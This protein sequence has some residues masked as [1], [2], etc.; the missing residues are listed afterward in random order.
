M[1]RE[2]MIDE[3]VLRAP[4][5]V[6]EHLQEAMRRHGHAPERCEHCQAAAELIRTNFREISAGA[7]LES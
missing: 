2:D 5:W 4:A 7:E 6:H 1:T 3:A